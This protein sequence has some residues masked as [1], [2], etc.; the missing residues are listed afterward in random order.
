MNTRL[1]LEAEK[2]VKLDT[3]DLHAHILWALISQSGRAPLQ[4]GHISKM[5]KN[6][7]GCRPS[8]Y[9]VR[10]ICDKLTVSDTVYR[11]VL[12]VNAVATVIGYTAGENAVLMLAG[13]VHTFI[14]N[15]T[16]Y[17]AVAT[18]IQPVRQA[19]IDVSNSIY[20]YNQELDAQADM[21]QEMLDD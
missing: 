16:L 12:R 17:E 2:Q 20:N 21:K 9:Q 5:V 1:L 10:T 6:S 13:L 19:A 3:L 18:A 8:A 7:S 14:M 15:R 4:V 11:Q